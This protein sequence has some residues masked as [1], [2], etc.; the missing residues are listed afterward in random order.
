LKRSAEI[1]KGS[2]RSLFILGL[3]FYFGLL[4]I[5]IF[6]V[7]LVL[8]PFVILG[9]LGILL[10][11]MRLLSFFDMMPIL[12]PAGFFVVFLAVALVDAVIVLP[13]TR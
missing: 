8:A 2:K 1:T 10:Q 5:N 6:L 12:I 4:V 9:A 7:I 3:K 13:P 11:G